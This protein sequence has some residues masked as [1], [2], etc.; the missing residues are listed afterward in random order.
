MKNLIFLFLN[1]NKRQQNICCGAQKNRLN[2]RV[3]LSTQN[4]C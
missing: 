1:Q 3:L 4:I 2:E